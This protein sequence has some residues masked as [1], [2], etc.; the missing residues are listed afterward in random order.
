MIKLYRQGRDGERGTDD[1]AKL[2]GV[3]GIVGRMVESDE[4]ESRQ[5]ALE[6]AVRRWVAG[7]PAVP[8]ARPAGVNAGYDA[9]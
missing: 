4:L 9:S 7:A 3:L 1:V 5:G 8:G 2:A 6:R